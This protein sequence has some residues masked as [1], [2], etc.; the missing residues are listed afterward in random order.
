MGQ[1]CQAE[2][3]E[4]HPSGCSYGL[5]WLRKLE[6]AKALERKTGIFGIYL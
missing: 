3:W 1:L 5:L 4:K 2:C 6:K